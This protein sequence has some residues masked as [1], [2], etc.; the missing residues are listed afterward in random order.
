MQLE[1]SEREQSAIIEGLRL[2]Q[3]QIEAHGIA[4]PAAGR[5]NYCGETV[6]AGKDLSA[7][8]IDALVENRIN[9][10]GAE[11]TQPTPEPIPKE[12]KATAK[13]LAQAMIR[14]RE[15]GVAVVTKSVRGEGDEGYSDEVEYQDATGSSV[16]V[17]EPLSNEL[18]DMLDEIIDIASGD[19]EDGDGGG[20][21]VTLVDGQIEIEGFSTV[22]EDQTHTH[23]IFTL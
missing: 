13:K 7:I 19:Y 2:L 8:E 18:G 1:I 11:D 17:P 14:L 23:K 15:L 20:C 3:K 21:T 4:S 12:L 10:I 5:I 16:D 6:P 22:S 9:L